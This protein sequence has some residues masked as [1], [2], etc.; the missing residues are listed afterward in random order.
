MIYLMDLAKATA[1]LKPVTSTE[2]TIGKTNSFHPDGLFSEVIFGS[3]ESP[4]RK[5]T[6][7][8]IELHCKVMHPSLIKPIERLNK[9]II[10]AIT[11][12]AAYKLDKGGMLIEDKAGEINSLNSVI[13]N[14]EKIL[15]RKEEDQYRIDLRNMVLAYHKRGLAFIDQ[16]LVMPAGF[17]EADV[18]DIHGGLRI[19]AV[20]DYYFKI[21]RHSM[22]IQSL[23]VNSGPMYD[24]L[25]QKMQQLIDD[26]YEFL[27][28]KISKKE[29]IV[30]QSILGKR[31]DF[32]GRAVIT[33]GGGKIKVDEI[34]IPFKA[35]VKLYEPFILYDLYNSGNV[36]RGKLGDLLKLWDPIST[37]SVPSLKSVLTS[38]SRGFKIPPELEEV[39]KA[40]VTRAIKDKVVIAKRDPAIHAE[41]VQGFKPVMVDGETIQLSIAKCT[42]YNAD[43][44]GDA[45]AIYIPVTKEAIEEAR[46][47]MISS[48]SKDSMNALSDEFSKDMVIGI[49]ALTQD[50]PF[51][52]APKVMKSDDELQTLHPLDIIRYDGEVTTVG[53]VLFN[54]I[55]PTKKLH[56]NKPISKSDVENLVKQVYKLYGSSEKE[57]Y[58]NFCNDMINLGMKYY[59]IMAPTFSLDDLMDISPSILALKEQLK[60]E[61]DPQKAQLIITHIEKELKNYLETKNTNIGLIGKAGGLKGYN[62][63]S[64]ILVS[65]GLITGPSGKTL[66]LSSSFADGFNSDDFFQ[67]GYGSRKGI[68]D[69]VINTSD[70]GYLSRQL[71]FALQR[72]EADPRIKD[73]RTKKYFT[74][75]VTPDLAKRLVGRNLVDPNGKIIPFDNKY[76]G[77]VVSLRSPLYCLSKDICLTCY[78]DLLLRNRTRYVGILAGEICGECLTQ[79]IMRTFHVGG[80]L[81]IKTVDVIN[82]LSRII[83][84][85]EKHYLLKSFTQ[86]GSKLIAQTDGE[87][88]IDISEYEDPHTDIQQTKDKLD[89][90]YAFFKIKYLSFMLDA[91]IDNKIEID[92]KDKVFLE[93]NGVISI[94]FSK[95]SVVFDCLP[96]AQ[97][98]SEKIK[99]ISALFSG[100]IPWRN[101]DHFCMK[102]YDIYSDLNKRA[103]L[104]HF[105]ILASN[106]LRDK[107]NPCYPARLN[108]NYDPII[109]SLKSVPGMESWLQAFAFENPKQAIT[110]GLVYTRPGDETILEKLITGNF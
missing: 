24:I 15:S 64:Q 10:L 89:L 105:E 87:I 70:T 35:L 103:D 11:R 98:F 9:K 47:K 46:D 40:S 94:K 63:A 75:K 80:S 101:S 102:L 12:K 78:G 59:T 106:L 58:V 4:D 41:S 57:V 56:I 50:S 3:K 42:A 81:N 95:G 88:Q 92:L 36:E 85:E 79:T 13:K 16:C 44:D 45:M 37:L 23:S 77:K 5:R 72:V 1:H 109:K 18:D 17:R 83:P 31:S 53:R 65:K 67:S 91:T 108:K 39:I 76:I 27:I 30:R 69:R 73:C 74:V 99:I 68:I 21:I 82:E 51:K 104:I 34:G 86:Q 19:P 32:T 48:E 110:T 97:I 93:S 60:K 71:V 22:Q 54:R 66:I 8:Y 62:Q 7:S 26:L 61:K 84:D 55:L 107:G 96:T 29:G 38:I 6:F 28:S 14:F 25:S 49:Y 33:G 2:Y 20:N 100:K 52:N 90:N 43:F